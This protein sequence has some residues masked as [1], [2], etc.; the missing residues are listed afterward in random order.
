[1]AFIQ[2]FHS[3]YVLKLLQAAPVNIIVGSHVWVEHPVQAW[4]D[5]EVFRING[6]EVHIRTTDG[7]TV[8]FVA[9][10]LCKWGFLIIRVKIFPTKY[11]AIVCPNDVLSRLLRQGTY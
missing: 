5:G 11:Y 7:K 6:E 2:P 8:S 3:F 4:I 9:H 10:L 1:M